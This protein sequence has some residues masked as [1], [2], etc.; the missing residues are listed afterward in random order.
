MSEP[1]PETV[2]ETAYEAAEHVIFEH[3]DTSQVRDLDITATFREG[4]FEI[5]VY[6]NAGGH[7]DEQDV[8]EAASEAAMRAVDYLFDNF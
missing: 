1:D 2:V 6:L 7:P 4:V 8:V 5:D 3:F